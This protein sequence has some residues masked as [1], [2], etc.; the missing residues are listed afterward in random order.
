MP[1]PRRCDVFCKIVDNFGDI[2][3]C[4]RLTQQLANE[5]HWH[6]R[7]LIDDY[8]VASQII[9]TLST[10][11]YTQTVKQ[12]TISHWDEALAIQLPE[13][14]IENFSCDVPEDYAKQV[15]TQQQTSDTPITWINLEYLSAEAWV[16][17][18]HLLPSQHPQLG[19]NKV[20]YY[21]GFSTNT[22]GL[23]REQ[24]LPQRR[25]QWQ[26]ESAQTSFWQSLG[27]DP[28]VLQHSIKVSLFCYPQADS[29]SLIDDLQAHS[30]AIC[31][32]IPSNADSDLVQMLTRQFEFNAAG[33]YQYNKLTIQMLPFLTQ[34][35]YDQLLASCDL[36]FVRGEDSWIRAIWSGQPFIWQPYIQS[37]E[38]HLV[39]LKAFL[40]Q[41]LQHTNSNDSI[42]K[43]I[44]QAH[45]QWSNAI[46]EQQ[47]THWSTILDQHKA[48]KAISAQAC[49]HYQD[50]ASL[51]QQLVHYWQNTQ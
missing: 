40:T 35:H 26:T 41:Y 48:W 11:P 22:G 21:P 33:Q 6:V 30:Q 7:L 9:P 18:C 15:A 51:T 43:L 44:Q 12:V 50:Q 49:L 13:L 29:L 23:L 19:L 3:V 4:W 8:A 32:F 10:T 37:E 25:Q 38:T 31:L 36:N 20:F 14:V 1:A 27:L 45:L 42:S 34:E 39:K 17:G 5:H 16:E 24:D 46:P 2:G 28:N 47:R